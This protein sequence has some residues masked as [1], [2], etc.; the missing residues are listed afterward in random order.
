[1]WVLLHR[2][3][4][5]DA[6]FELVKVVYP[7]DPLQAAKNYGFKEPIDGFIDGGQPTAYPTNKFVLKQ[8][9]KSP[10]F[11]STMLVMC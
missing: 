9:D 7:D 2:G 10:H 4:P 6:I 8:Q 5:P 11:K 1:M 3:L